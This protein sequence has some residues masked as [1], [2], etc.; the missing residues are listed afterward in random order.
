MFC[1]PCSGDLCEIHNFLF[2]QGLPLLL[3]RIQ[4]MKYKC[5]AVT[6]AILVFLV[7]LQAAAAAMPEMQGK[8]NS[9]GS[10]EGLKIQADD[11]G[12]AS[13]SGLNHAFIWDKTTGM[14]DL[15]TL[16]GSYSY[17]YAINDMGQVVGYS[18]NASGEIHAFI[19]NRM[20]GMKDL[21][22]LGGSQS[23]VYAIN[24]MGQVVGQSKDASGFDHAFICLL[25]TSPS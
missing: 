8:L 14:K 11:I 6:A 15:G 24:D 18:F 20:T 23:L 16:G 21:G 7:A 2:M 9:H 5:G 19:W 4:T 12:I 13:A 22:T 10:Q 1:K 25:Y 3:K 17:P